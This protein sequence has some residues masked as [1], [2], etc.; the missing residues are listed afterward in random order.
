MGS[1]EPGNKKTTQ[2]TSRIK[3]NNELSSL[4]F[5]KLISLLF[6]ERQPANNFLFLYW[7]VFEKRREKDIPS[8]L[9]ELK[10]ERKEAN[11][12]ASLIGFFMEDE[13]KDNSTVWLLSS[14]YYSSN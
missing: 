5:I 12:F 9:P 7:F 11:G 3:E 4:Y 14:Q 6:E 13:N 8:T 1:A 2:L 10:N